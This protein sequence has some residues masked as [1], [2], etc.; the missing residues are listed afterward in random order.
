MNSV[1][2]LRDVKLSFDGAVV[3]KDISI[4]IAS[5]EFV[6]LLGPTGSG[7]SSLL[8]LL[9]ADQKP[10]D[11]VIKVNGFQVDEIKDK[12]V[13]FL[14]RSLGVIFQDFELL[15]DRSVEDNLEFVMKATGWKSAAQI[16]QKIDE[17]LEKVHLSKISRQKMPHQL[18]G[19]EQQRVAIARA[20]INN[21]KVLIADEPTGNLDPKVSRSI[22]QLFKEINSDGT[23][24]IMATH[25]HSFLRLNPERSIVFE[26]GSIKDISKK[27]V[28]QKLDL[29][30]A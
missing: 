8:R 15:T 2:S 24:V 29:N 12:E 16:N 1:V 18:S 10:T 26:K 6:Y 4:D 23:C 11:G 20:L 5:G 30:Q 19:G 27:Q 7:K 14:R 21:P 9:Y 3:L 17:V 25:Q 13:P 28:Q 22:L